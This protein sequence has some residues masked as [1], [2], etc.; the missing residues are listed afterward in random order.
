M[1]TIRLLIFE[2]TQ[3][4]LLHNITSTHSRLITL[5]I[6]QEKSCAETAKTAASEQPRGGGAV[7]RQPLI[8]FFGLPVR[9]DTTTYIWKYLPNKQHRIYFTK[10]FVQKRFYSIG[11]KS[12]S[13]KGIFNINLMRISPQ[14]Q[15]MFS[16]F[17]HFSTRYFSTPKS[18]AF[19]TPLHPLNKV[20]SGTL[21]VV[22]YAHS[23]FCSFT[24]PKRPPNFT[25][26]IIPPTKYEVET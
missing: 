1:S 8:P 9:H 5:Q 24:T 10:Y 20:S 7:Q 22:I 21:V 15:N 3:Q 12:L 14:Q 19:I 2:N 26:R 11:L 6:I 13:K 16:Q 18:R 4:S 25:K 23:R 17:P